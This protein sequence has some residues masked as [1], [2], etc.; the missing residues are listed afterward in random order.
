LET[1][2]ALSEEKSVPVEESRF[3]Q[4]F[5]KQTLEIFQQLSTFPKL[6]AELVDD[7][8]NSTW[9]MSPHWHESGEQKAGTI[10]RVTAFRS[11]NEMV[12]QGPLFHVAN[13]L[14][15]TP[16][17][18]SKNNSDY[19]V[20]DLQNIPESYL[21]RTNYGPAVPEEE[22][23]NRMTKCTWDQ[24]KS[25]GD[26]YRLALRNMIG[27]N[28]ERSLISAVIPPNILHVDAVE[29]VAFKDQSHLF[30]FSGLAFSLIFDFL[31]KASGI[32]N[33]RS[34]YASQL[35]FI[36]VSKQVKYRVL[37]LSSLTD[38]YKELW[39][40]TLRKPVEMKWS[41]DLPMVNSGAIGTSWSR[42]SVLVNEFMRRLALVEIDVLIAQAFRLTLDQLIEIYRI[43]FPVLQDNEASTW[44]DQS[45]RIV[46]TGSKGL[47]GVGY[48]NEKGKSP[49][50]KDWES[51]LESNPSEL[52]CTAEDDTM[53]DGP[54]TVERRFV[55]PFFKCDRVEDY[56]LAWAHFEKLEREGAL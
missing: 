53:P 50:R 54:Q 8:G 11:L 16:R 40:N 17:R 20:I 4:P 7:N 36:R 42:E 43:Y 37:A 5:S 34:S 10:K 1:I 30:D 39:V 32:S 19:D 21:P 18:V 15:K 44:Y 38:L 3:I 12:I 26:F 45:G 46:W 29:S 25:H 49:G 47:F 35:P 28:G 2:H 27:L 23:R 9:Q 51:I 33:L 22:Y 6:G 52:I 55:G 14:Y 31:V 56:K 24:T 48:L 13:P 41:S